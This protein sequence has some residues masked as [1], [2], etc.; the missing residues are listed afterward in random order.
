MGGIQYNEEDDISAYVTLCDSN[1]ETIWG[2]SIIRR[3]GCEL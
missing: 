3:S 1:N 2:V